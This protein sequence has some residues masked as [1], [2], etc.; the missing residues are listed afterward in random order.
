ME[1]K[2]RQVQVQIA[3]TITGFNYS[4]CKILY[5]EAVRLLKTDI[6][7]GNDDIFPIDKN[8][9][10]K[11]KEINKKVEETEWHE[12][13]GEK[14]ILF[15]KEFVNKQTLKVKDDSILNNIFLALSDQIVERFHFSVGGNPAGLEVEIAEI[16]CF[17]DKVKKYLAMFE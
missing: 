16:L 1:M 4:Y 12:F 8:G 15:K 2:L 14:R 11:I 10:K 5:D 17:L 13:Q 9:L 3:G 6:V 7:D